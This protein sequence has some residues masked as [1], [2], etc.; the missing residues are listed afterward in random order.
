MLADDGTKLQV[1]NQNKHAVRC[2]ILPHI[3]TAISSTETKPTKNV[4]NFAVLKHFRDFQFTRC[5][6]SLDLKAVK[7]EI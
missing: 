3:P 1:S 4:S 2:L 5:Y 6:V 7:L